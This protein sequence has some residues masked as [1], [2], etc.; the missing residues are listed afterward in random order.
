MDT[1]LFGKEL[2]RM[3]DTYPDCK[4]C[5]V[6]T[7]FLGQCRTWCLEFPEEAVAI[8][9]KWRKEHPLKTNADK[10]KEVFGCNPI[11]AGYQAGHAK[12]LGLPE[13]WWQASY[14]EPKEDNV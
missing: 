12:A 9:E 6:P 14:E 11:P 7:K 5:E 1:A 4:S 13:H 10:F 3:C 2:N 8:V